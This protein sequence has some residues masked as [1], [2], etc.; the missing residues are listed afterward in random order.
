MR[1]KNGTTSFLPKTKKGGKVRFCEEVTYI[2]NREKMC[3]TKDQATQIYEEVERNELINIQIASQDIKD[4]SKFRKRQVKE[5]DIDTNINPYQKASSNANSRDENKIEQMI[6]WSI[7]SNKIR[8]IDSCMNV[9]PR[10]TIRPL[11]EKKPRRLLST[12]EIKEDQIP[13]MIFEEN[14]VKEAVGTQTFP[15]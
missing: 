8:Y 2:S 14:K 6:N 13:D 10:L 7:F 4:K 11:E 1:G 15:A 12:L 5:E 9:T 3:L